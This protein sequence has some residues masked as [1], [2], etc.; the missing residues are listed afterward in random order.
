MTLYREALLGRTTEEILGF[1]SSIDEDR[2]IVVE[3]IEVLITHVKHLTSK[4][5]IPKDAGDK[6]LKVLKDLLND[7]EVLFKVKAE[8]IHEAIEKY[9]RDVVGEDAGWIALGRSRNDHVATALRLKTRKILLQYIDKLLRIRKSLLDKSCKYV[10]TPLPLTTHLQVAQLSTVAHYLTYIEEMLREY[11]D[12]IF[13]VLGSVVNKSP[14]GA[15]AV[16]GTTVPLDRYELASMLGFNDVVGNTLLATGSRDFIAITASVITSLITS[17]SRIAEDFIIWST[18]QFNYVEP[19]PQHLAT[20]SMMPH[21]KNLVTMEVLRALSGE[22]IGHLTAILSIL[23]ANPSGYNLDLQEI[24]KHLLTLLT[25][26]LEALVIFEDFIKN[27]EFNANTL[28]NEVIKYSLIITDIAEQVAIKCGKPYREVHRE[29][30]SVLRDLGGSDLGS[31]CREL[32][33]RLN[34]SD[35]GLCS[36]SLSDVLRLR[37]VYG[38]PNPELML[39]YISKEREVLDSDYNRYINLVKALGVNQ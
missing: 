25:T 36:I 33:R 12:M 28:S 20:S 11:T 10:E 4:G 27:V 2:L 15:G 7:N 23:K 16:A 37:K 22:V 18:P 21:K 1:I 35:E 39:K 32:C 29:V 14:L 26:T 30:A 9:L 3:V 5:L 34:V 17:L 19:P 8:D 13:Y 31:V 6:V 24:N 38:S